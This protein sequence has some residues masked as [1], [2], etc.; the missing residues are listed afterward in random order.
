[1]QINFSIASEAQLVSE[2]FHIEV[3]DQYKT[4][5]NARPSDLLPVITGE[6]PE[7]LSFFYWGINP[8]FSKSK[9]VSNK[10]LYAPVEDI[11]NK[12]SLRKALQLQRCVIIADGFYDWKEIARKEKVP[13]RFHLQNNSPFAI[14]GLWDS[15]ENESGDTIHTFMMITTPASAEVRKVSLRM[16]AILNEDLMMEWLNED[17]T[18]D[19]LLSFVKP[20]EEEHIFQYTVNPKLADPTFDNELLWKKVPAANQFGNLTL[21]N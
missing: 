21:F 20:F 11:P 19:S 18:A 1:M 10:L 3:T 13:Y 12:P 14:A 5:Y 9:S 15:F 2:H 17:N 7:G 16:P 6:N 8:S 4:T